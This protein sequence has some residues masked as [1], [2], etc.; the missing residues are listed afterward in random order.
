MD[1]EQ[2]GDNQMQIKREKCNHYFSKNAMMWFNCDRDINTRELNCYN[3]V[4]CSAT[5]YVYDIFDILWHFWTWLIKMELGLNLLSS[6]KI[7]TMQ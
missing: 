5:I 1:E 4:M 2:S 7:K 6:T 3:R